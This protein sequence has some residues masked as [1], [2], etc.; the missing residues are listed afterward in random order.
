MAAKKPPR[1]NLPRRP[2]GSSKHS[3]NETQNNLDP[4]AEVGVLALPAADDSEEL[5]RRS[6]VPFPMDETQKNSPPPAE[7]G[8]LALPAADDSEEL[9][10]HSAVPFPIVGVGASAGGLEAFTQFLQ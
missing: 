5:Q 10:R 8:V 4:P 6:A 7:V 3:A 2:S 1:N 9:Q